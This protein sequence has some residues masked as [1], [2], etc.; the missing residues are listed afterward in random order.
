MERTQGARME[1]TQGARMERTQGARMERTQGARMER[2]QGARMERTTASAS[3]ERVRGQ[4][5]PVIHWPHD[6]HQCRQWHHDSS[7]DS[8][9]LN[10]CAGSDSASL[11][12][13]QLDPS[14]G[15]MVTVPRSSDWPRRAAR[16]LGRARR[17]PAPVTACRADGP[18]W[19]G[20]RGARDPSRPKM[21][22]QLGALPSC[23]TARLQG[24]SGR[25][26]EQ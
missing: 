24:R 11:P 21:Y 17:R 26:N 19:P 22:R 2:T 20:L 12:G 9:S 15:P 4:A 13:W 23:N 1:R 14:P 5:R 16:S 8:L 6:D 10:S 25:E 3:S 7:S 18:G